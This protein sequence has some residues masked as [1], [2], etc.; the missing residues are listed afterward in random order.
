VIIAQMAVANLPVPMTA[1]IGRARELERIGE[2]V[3]RTRLVTITGTGGVGEARLALDVATREIGR[4][5][6][7]VWLVDLAVGSGPPDVSRALGRV[8]GR[9]ERLDAP[10]VRTVEGARTQPPA[11]SAS[12]TGRSLRPGRASTAIKWRI[13]SRPDGRGGG[14]P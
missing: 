1:L 13:R 5:A 10:S 14:R 4:R 9:G 2:T 12:G 6:S 3:R 11:G 8:V 7:G